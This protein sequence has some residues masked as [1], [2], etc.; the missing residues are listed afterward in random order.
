MRISLRERRWLQ[1]VL[2][3]F[4]SF[5]FFFGFCFGLYI[6][7]VF[8]VLACHFLPVAKHTTCVADALSS[9]PRD[10]SP[11]GRKSDLVWSDDLNN[12]IFQVYR[13]L[14][15]FLVCSV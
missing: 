4:L 13:N 14:V 9:S 8:S 5:F 6:L 10:W 3:L 11:T 2:H 7:L 12:S 15:R 1:N